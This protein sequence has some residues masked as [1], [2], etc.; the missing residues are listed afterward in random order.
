MWPPDFR[1]PKSGDVGDVGDGGDGPDTGYVDFL[2]TSSLRG[3]GSGDGPGSEVRGWPTECPVCMIGNALATE[4][5]TTSR[6]TYTLMG[7]CLHRPRVQ[8]CFHGTHEAPLFGRHS[9]C[10]S[11][12]GCESS[13]T[14][15]GRCERWV[16]AAHTSR[17][18]SDKHCTAVRDSNTY[19]KTNAG[20][21]KYIMP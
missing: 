16:H 8:P 19:I 17:L 3:P 13:D 6:A 18:R 1:P 15:A 5:T 21:K 2:W 20:P 10:F 12:V 9:C 7:S 11:V 14:S 4:M